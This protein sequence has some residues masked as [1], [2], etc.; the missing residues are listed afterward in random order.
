[1]DVLRTPDARFAAP[2]DFAAL[3][4]RD[5]AWGEAWAGLAPGATLD[6]IA[7]ASRCLQEDAGAEPAATIRRRLG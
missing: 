3:R 5:R 4:R 6:R 1:M 7:G 2:A